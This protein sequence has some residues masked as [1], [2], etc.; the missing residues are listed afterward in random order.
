[1]I[2][3]TFSLLSAP[4]SLLGIEA[5][6]LGC[7]PILDKLPPSPPPRCPSSLSN[8]ITMLLISQMSGYRKVGSSIWLPQWALAWSEWET[9]INRAA[10]ALGAP[11]IFSSAALAYRDGTGKQLE[12]DRALAPSQSPSCIPLAM[13]ALPQTPQKGESR[14]L[15]ALRRTQPLLGCLP[16]T[17]NTSHFLSNIFPSECCPSWHLC[18]PHNPDSQM[19]LSGRWH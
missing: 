9:G 4:P 6:V 15:P 7:H 11:R 17:P 10:T 13:V 2:R 19:N 14:I 12:E 5:E 16:N 3:A 18:P 1:M 8:I